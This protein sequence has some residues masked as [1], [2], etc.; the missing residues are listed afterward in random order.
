MS[1]SPEPA[2]AARVAR[3]LSSSESDSTP[4]G[5]AGGGFTFA[6]PAKKHNSE[7]YGLSPAYSKVEMQLSAEGTGSS[8][9]I[10]DVLRIVLKK[11]EALAENMMSLICT[12]M[13][14][15]EISASAFA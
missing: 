1:D 4:R 2:P 9:D 11:R 14:M 5:S 7:E 8:T 10:S 13:S 12:R 15:L 6:G 3:A